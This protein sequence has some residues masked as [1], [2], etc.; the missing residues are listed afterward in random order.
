MSGAMGDRPAAIECEAAVR[1]MYDYLDSRLDALAATRVTSHLETCRA[2]AAHY[3][4]AR[5]LLDHLPAA[6]PVTDVPQELRHRI[7]SALTAAGYVP[8]STRG[9]NSL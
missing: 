2:C 9:G 4:F 3:T 8:A 7:T 1:A 5:R 6:V